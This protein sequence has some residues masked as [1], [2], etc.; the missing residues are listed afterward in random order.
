LA[1]LV[2]RLAGWQRLP[3]CAGM[4]TLAFLGAMTVTGWRQSAVVLLPIAVMGAVVIAWA[5]S[6]APGWALK[7][8]GSGPLAW[9][10]K[11]SYGMYLWQ[12]P[13]IVT[14]AEVS[15]GLRAALAVPLIYGIA[16]ISWFVV[17]RPFQRRGP[18]LAEPA[19]RPATGRPAATLA[20]GA[21]ESGT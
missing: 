2:N 10:G 12:S 20:L 1:I 14:L 16:V 5:A 19:Q 6:C 21:T 18:R 4:A 3:Q 9:T 8:L 17:E 7:A 11:I 15:P 13:V